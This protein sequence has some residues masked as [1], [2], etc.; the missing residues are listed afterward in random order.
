MTDPRYDVLLHLLP[1]N[2]LAEAR[3][4]AR[5][6]ERDELFRL[7]VLRWMWLVVPAGVAF[8]AISVV[9]AFGVFGACMMFAGVTGPVPGKP[10]PWLLVLAKLLGS[11]FWFGAICSQFYALFS[12]LE[13]RAFRGERVRQIDPAADMTLSPPG[14]ASSVLWLVATFVFAPLTVVAATARTSVSSLALAVALAFLAPIIYS[15]FGRQ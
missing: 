12:W 15:L 9:C 5:S 1:S 7:C 11:F 10:D 4:L 8:L 14:R 2:G 3:Q 13:R 6:F